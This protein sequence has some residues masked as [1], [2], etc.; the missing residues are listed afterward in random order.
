[1]S[2]H[3]VNMKVI[4]I[5]DWADISLELTTTQEFRRA[6]PQPDLIR[7]PKSQHS[8]IIFAKPV[9]ETKHHHQKTQ[10]CLPHSHRC[11]SSP[12]HWPTAKLLPILLHHPFC[13]SH[14]LHW[15]LHSLLVVHSVAWY[16]SSLTCYVR[17]SPVFGNQF[18]EM[19]VPTWHAHTGTGGRP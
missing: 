17:A 1:M 15:L 12:S 18:D 9:E 11:H 4:V 16:I 13:I 6:P 14:I 8:V 3:S 7:P 19:N 10:T 5:D 2:R